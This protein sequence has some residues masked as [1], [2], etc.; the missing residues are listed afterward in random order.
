MKMAEKL[1][2]EVVEKLHEVN[3][4]Q[5]K[6]ICERLQLTI[7][8]KKKDNKVAVFNGIMRHLTSEEVE[9]SADEGM[10]AFLKL[11]DELKLMLEID[12]N[13]DKKKVKKEVGPSGQ[14]MVA[15]AGSSST[16]S[17]TGKARIELHKLREF[18]ITGGTVG[19]T[20]NA[21]DYRSL[22][23]Q[24][25][26][27]RSMNYTSKEIVA[28]VI[29]AMKA[30]SSLRKYFEGRLDLTEDV[31]MKTLR[32]F[33]NVKDST[34]LLDEMVN[35]SQEPT[36]S[37]MN[38]LL[39][40]MGL[41]DNIMTLTMEE[42]CPLGEELVRRRFFHAVSV[43]LK[44]DTIRLE[45]RQLLKDGR[46]TDEDLLKELSQVVAREAENRKKTKNGKNAASNMLNV[47]TE[48]VK[49]EMDDDKCKDSVV[50][51]EI[52]QLYTKVNELS[53]RFNKVAT[54]DEITELKRQVNDSNNENGS[55]S[56]WNRRSNGRRGFVKCKACEEKKAFCTHCSVCGSGGHKRNECPTKN[57]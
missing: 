16:E 46:M 23:Y 33:Y 2:K 20:D 54:K 6:E 12:D 24:M 3:L 45:L 44:K 52:K 34:L 5:L 31:V 8:D 50:L 40:M 28:G 11:N 37:E 32:S 43:G 7:A 19:G 13:D 27:G 36:E 14:E 1:R 35:S 47:E 10:A 18:K 49:R 9:D 4:D 57:E 22:C 39:R 30:G 15:K 48:E 41:R 26:E 29:K 42:D 21:L 17:L 38:F 53:T 56:R 25:Q 51:A 55:G